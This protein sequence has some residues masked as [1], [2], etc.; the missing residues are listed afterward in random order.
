MRDV[1]AEGGI[2]RHSRATLELCSAQTSEDK[3]EGETLGSSDRK[4]EETLKSLQR[5]ERD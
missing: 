3:G 2:E 4:D 1:K 5:N